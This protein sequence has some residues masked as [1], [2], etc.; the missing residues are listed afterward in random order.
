MSGVE[1]GH[2]R[3][4][5]SSVTCTEIRHLLT[6]NAD[7]SS[8]DEF[9]Y[10]IREWCRVVDS[11]SV[12]GQAARFKSNHALSLGDSFVVATAAETGATAFVGADD[13]FEDIAAIDIERVRTDPA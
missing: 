4:Y 13:D 9:V 8:A 10:R 6:N 3:G 1:R 12:W 7:A 11:E 2:E 5:I